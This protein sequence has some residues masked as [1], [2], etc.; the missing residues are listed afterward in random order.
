M[1]PAFTTLSAF[2]CVFL[3]LLTVERSILVWRGLSSPDRR[4]GSLEADHME[5][6]AYTHGEV[7][8]LRDSIHGVQLKAEATAAVF[9][10]RFARLETKTDVQTATLDK[11][12]GLV[13]SALLKKE[14]TGS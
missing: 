5:L 12:L 7:H 2:G 9:M 10:E 11:L 13:E 8:Q 4:P 1:D 6:K 14:S 3:A